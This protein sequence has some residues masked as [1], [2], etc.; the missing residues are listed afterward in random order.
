MPAFASDIMFMAWWWSTS[1]YVCN[2]SVKT[3]VVLIQA[4]KP[5][6]ALMLKSYFLRK[7]Y[8]KSDMFW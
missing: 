8:H 3:T 5:T 4:I 7:I 6:N 1:K 2:N